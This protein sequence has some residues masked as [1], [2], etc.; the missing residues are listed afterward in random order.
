LDIPVLYIN[1]RKPGVTYSLIREA[2]AMSTGR[3][4]AFQNCFIDPLFV[5]H[6]RDL[7]ASLA[8]SCPASVYW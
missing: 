3:P 5:L 7:T 6:L 2:T 8:L 1:T 4:C